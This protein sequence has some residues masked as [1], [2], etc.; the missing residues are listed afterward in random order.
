MPHIAGFII[1]GAICA[2]LMAETAPKAGQYG[3]GYA[4]FA[5]LKGE[6][7]VA[8]ADGSHARPLSPDP[9]WDA[10]ASFSN[11]GRW[12]IFTSN[13]QGSAD[14]FRVHPDGSGLERLTDDPAFDDQ[15]ALSPDGRQLAFVSTRTGRAEIWSLD[16]GT[17]ALKNLTGRS[18]GKL[19][20]RLV[21]GQGV[22]RVLVRPS[23]AAAGPP[24]VVRVDSVDRDLRD[25]RGRHRHP[26][27]LRDAS[28]RLRRAV[29][30][31]QPVRR[32]DPVAGVGA[33]VGEG[34]VKPVRMP[35]RRP[36]ITEGIAED[37][38]STQSAMASYVPQN[39]R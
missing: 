17:K 6:V 32:C 35:R 22:D 14:I 30:H 21:S 31:R 15:A 19:P 18:R 13:R 36:G 33:R 39:V 10:N 3:I 37:R 27:N 12:V 4:S 7:F 9:G 28:R 1:G 29:P 5:L 24:G 20:A 8:D 34:P 26:Q 23:V 11:D 25:A 2:Q 38:V 16:L